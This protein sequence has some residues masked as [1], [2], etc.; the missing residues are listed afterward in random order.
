[1]STVEVIAI[2]PFDGHHPGATVT[3][4]E[5]QSEQLFAKGLA[6][7]KGPHGTKV[8]PP[9]ANKARPSKAA[10][11]GR[12]SSASPAARRSRTTTATTSEDGG[13]QEPTGE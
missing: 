11:Q 9:L 10:G 13:K 5:R 6:K 12:T 7:I 8:K 2:E 1:M 3:V 4:T